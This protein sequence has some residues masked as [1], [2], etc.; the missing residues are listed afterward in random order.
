[1]DERELLDDGETCPR[2]KY[3]IPADE[4]MPGPDDRSRRGTEDQDF[5]SAAIELRLSPRARDWAAGGR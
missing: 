5:R 2:C 3:V 1:M 4:P